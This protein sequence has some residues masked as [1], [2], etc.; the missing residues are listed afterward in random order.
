M[1]TNQTPPCQVRGWFSVFPP[2]SSPELTHPSP[3]QDTH[4][5]ADS[6]AEDNSYPSYDDQHGQHVGS[7]FLRL[8]LFLRDNASDDL[9][10]PTNEDIEESRALQTLLGETPPGKRDAEDKSKASGGSGGGAGGGGRGGKD[11]GGE[12]GSATV[13]VGSGTV[14]RLLGIPVSL[15]GTVK[16]VQV[17]VEGVLDALEV[18]RKIRSLGVGLGGHGVRIMWLQYS[19]LHGRLACLHVPVCTLG[20]PRGLF[21]RGFMGWSACL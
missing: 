15:W 20:L 18:R 19:V 11:G 7:L 2:G 5:A 12:A 8:Q 10:P 14:A 17:A 9:V 3:Q 1:P 16:D 6:H 13:G 4:N 21:V